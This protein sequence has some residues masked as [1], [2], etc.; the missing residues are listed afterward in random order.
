M[1]EL[2][3]LRDFAR[4]TI[5]ETEL[6]RNLT[7]DADIEEYENDEAFMQECTDLC[8]PTMIQMMMNESME[9]I[10]ESMDE[11][12][13]QAYI[14]V[15]NYLIGQGIISEAA[16]VHINNP[17]LN[18]VHL[19]KQAQ[20]KRLTTII[21]LKMARKAGHKSYK[22]Y[23]MGQKIKKVNMEEMRKLYGAKAER[24]AKKLW[25]K[26]RKSSKVAAVVDSKKPAKGKK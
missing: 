6:R 25:A 17:K 24:L 16:S 20:I 3:N 14:T 7:T 18:V 15:Q 12:T 8:M 9:D 2:K 4:G 22:K 26:T 11:A 1:Y 13:A 19:N 5:N 23:K 21:T 10:F